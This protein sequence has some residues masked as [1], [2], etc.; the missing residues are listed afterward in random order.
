MLASRTICALKCPLSRSC[1]GATTMT[2]ECPILHSD[3]ILSYGYEMFPRILYDLLRR[4]FVHWTL[5]NLHVGGAT[6]RW[7]SECESA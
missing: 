6:A 3:L 4:S 2:G 5:L 1:R 7:L